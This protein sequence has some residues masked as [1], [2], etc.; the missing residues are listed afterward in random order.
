VRI[1]FGSL[2]E[3]ARTSSG[4]GYGDGC[5]YGYGYGCGD[6]DGSGESSGYS[7]EDFEVVRCG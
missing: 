5:S 2:P 3:W 4:H 7:C 6:G 1:V